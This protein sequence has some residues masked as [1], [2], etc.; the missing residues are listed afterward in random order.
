MS[1]L[2]ASDHKDFISLRELLDVTDG[3]LATHLKSLEKSRY[4]SFEK[5]FVNRKPRTK[6]YATEQGR[7]A[8]QKHINAI[9]EL[10]R[11]N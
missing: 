9:E 10:L 5:E 3:N 7:K 2:V 11:I 6:Y 1:A 4:I 8:F